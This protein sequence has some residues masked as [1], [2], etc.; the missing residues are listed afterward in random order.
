MNKIKNVL[1][2]DKDEF[3][4]E[5]IDKLLAEDELVLDRKEKLTEKIIDRVIT[6]VLF[7]IYIL[8][9]PVWIYEDRT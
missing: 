3:P 4:L 1:N 7:T 2:K 5:L 9:F 6:A 8:L